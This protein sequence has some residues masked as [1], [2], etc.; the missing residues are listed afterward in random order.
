M[1]VFP[2]PFTPTTK[3]TYGTVSSSTSKASKSELFS[4]R[5][6]T[7]SSFNILFNSFTLL[8]L[9][10]DTL[11]SILSIILTVVSTPTSEVISISSRSSNTSASIFDLPRTADFNFA[12]KLFLVFSKPFLIDSWSESS[13]SS[14]SSSTSSCSSTRRR[15]LSASGALEMT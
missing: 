6:L 4:A 9:S 8:Y 12:K 14:Y 10:F 7:I 1:V 5:I 13:S 11:S 3:I 15:M 2:T